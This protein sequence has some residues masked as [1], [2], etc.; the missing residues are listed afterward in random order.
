LDEQAFYAIKKWKFRPAK[1]KDGTSVAVIVPVEV[2]F[3]LY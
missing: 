3:R 2:T 1:N